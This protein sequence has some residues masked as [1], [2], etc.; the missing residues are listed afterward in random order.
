MTLV[1]I[2]LYCI[3]KC[4]RSYPTPF[5][6]ILGINIPLLPHFWISKLLS[7]HKL[8][9]AFSKMNY[10]QIFEFS[11]TAFRS[12]FGRNIPRK[13][14]WYVYKNLFLRHISNLVKYPDIKLKRETLILVVPQ[15]S[16]CNLRNMLG[17][18][19]PNLWTLLA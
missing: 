14:K 8:F 10:S 18:E 1:K 7:S 3:L 17:I 9:L 5:R 12:T 13:M 6:S 16:I 11:K 19:I 15:F 4:V 2:S